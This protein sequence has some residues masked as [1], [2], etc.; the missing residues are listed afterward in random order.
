MKILFINTLYFPDIGGGAEIIFQD[1]VEGIASKGHEVLV[2]TTK[3]PTLIDK[4][5]VVNGINI[6]RIGLF[7]IYWHYKR[8]NYPS[9]I[10]AIWHLLDVFN[11]VMLIKVLFYVYKF[12]PNIINI[13]NIQGFS[14]SLWLIEKIFNIPI[15]QVVHDQNSICPNVNMLFN[16]RICKNRCLKC[17]VFR[18]PHRYL[19]KNITCLVGVSNFIIGQHIKFDLFKNSNKFLI[20]NSR[21]INIVRKF[22]LPSK[23]IKFGY[24]G[25]L[26]PAKGLDYLLNSFYGL[27]S[28][29]YSL[30]I[31]GEGDSAYTD[32]LN[33]K[34]NK[35][36]I[37]AKLVGFSDQS[38]F[39]R[40]IDVLIV[41]SI[42]NDTFPTVIIESLSSGVPVIGSNRGGIPEAITTNVNGI[43]FD[44]DDEF[45]LHKIILKLFN[46]DEF[47]FSLIN[48]ARLFDKK[49]SNREKWLDD[50]INIFEKYIK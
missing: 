29:K 6:I 39:F 42:W 22:N 9:F 27:E 8:K 14:S 19:S 11:P 26:V 25:S 20:Y 48:K 50:Y 35:L 15:V 1:L 16:G 47:L 43:I 3:K 28:D 18:F 12:N 37:N 36:K 44:P 30:I 33:Q 45:A 17:S 38:D 10:R 34:I 2:L 23:K 49:Y 46:S 32:H 24:I 5:E 31:A 21:K 13:H 7:N 40:N 41:P 4:V